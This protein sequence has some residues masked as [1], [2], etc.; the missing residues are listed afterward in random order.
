MRGTASSMTHT[1]VLGFNIGV[2]EVAFVMEILQA[3]QNLLRDNLNKR[4]RDA[5]RFVA[6]NKR[7]EV[8]PQRFTHNADVHLVGSGMRE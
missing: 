1:Y 2:H 5:F 8:L 4:A 3:K 7:Q 6:L